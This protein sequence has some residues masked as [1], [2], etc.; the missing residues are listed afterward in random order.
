MC[1]SVWSRRKALLVMDH[2]SG[3]TW[4]FN[5]YAK[6]ASSFPTRSG[7]R[8]TPSDFGPF[9]S[10]MCSLGFVTTPYSAREPSELTSASVYNHRKWIPSP[11]FSCILRSSWGQAIFSLLVY[12]DLQRSSFPE[13]KHCPAFSHRA[14]EFAESLKLF[15]AS[16][17]ILTH[18]PQTGI[19]EEQEVKLSE[20][21]LPRG[22]LGGWLAPYGSFQT[23]CLFFFSCFPG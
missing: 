21:Y 12:A 13:A 6:L 23:T 8:H 11:P 22:L 1:A 19:T 14:L 4:C 9:A 10:R 18:I 16:W 2:L 17:W 3:A 15:Q 20:L 7:H 5:R